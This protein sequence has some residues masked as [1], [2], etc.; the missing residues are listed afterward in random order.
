MLLALI[1]SALTRETTVVQFRTQERLTVVFRGHSVSNALE[2]QNV[3]GFSAAR[4][5]ARGLGNRQQTERDSVTS[6]SGLEIPDDRHCTTRTSRAKIIAVGK[7][8]GCLL[9]VL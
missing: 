6:D 8:R 3:V 1:P 5:S 9:A 4:L 7:T 2:Y